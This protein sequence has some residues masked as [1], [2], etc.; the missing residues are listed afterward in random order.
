MKI[1]SSIKPKRFPSSALISPDKVLTIFGVSAIKN[2]QSPGFEPV[3][4]NISSL[5][6]SG[7]NL[8]I[9]PWNVP[10]SNTR[11]QARPLAL[12]SFIA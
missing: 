4:F 9:G 1:F 8:A 12:H 10:S 5:A 6:L 11:S 7:I 3:L 2:K